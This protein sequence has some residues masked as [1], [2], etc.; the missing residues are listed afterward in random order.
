MHESFQIMFD[1]NRERLVRND[2]IKGHNTWVE[3]SLMHVCACVPMHNPIWVL[4]PL[5]KFIGFSCLFALLVTPKQGLKVD[6][7]SRLVRSINRLS[8]SE[9]GFT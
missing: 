1:F 6:N 3:I 2:G 7:D 5:I 9:F 4:Q 8:N